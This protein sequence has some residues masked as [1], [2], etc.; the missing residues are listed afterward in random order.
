MEK[1]NL[2][3]YPIHKLPRIKFKQKNKDEKQRKVLKINTKFKK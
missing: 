3:Y 1:Q 2:K